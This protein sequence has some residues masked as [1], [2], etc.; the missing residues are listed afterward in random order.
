MQ[1][2]TQICNHWVSQGEHL[3]YAQTC[4]QKEFEQNIHMIYTV[5]KL[6]LHTFYKDTPHSTHSCPNFDLYLHQL[7]SI[8]LPTYLY[9]NSLYSQDTYYRNCVFSRY[10][11]NF[12]CN[13]NL[14]WNLKLRCYEVLDQGAL[15][16][17]KRSSLWSNILC[18]FPASVRVFLLALTSILWSI[19]G[20]RLVWM[21]RNW[22]LPRS[23]SVSRNQESNRAWSWR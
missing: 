3:S 8:F 12:I 21:Y 7:R 22:S 23:R 19:L 17:T 15:L 18:Y 1:V 2:H 14:I 11:D 6:T 10:L 9:W 16:K 13:I 20:T 5:R 4:K